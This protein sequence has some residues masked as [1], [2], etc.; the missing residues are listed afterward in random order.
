[1]RREA[2]LERKIREF[3]HTNGGLCLKQD[4]AVYKGIPDRLI[5]C[6]NGRMFFVELKDKDGVV[7]EIQH[8]WLNKLRN[9]GVD[10]YVVNDFEKFRGLWDG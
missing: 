5:I 6:P 8:H 4:A 3:C 2:A 10:A 7:A 9:M 1:M